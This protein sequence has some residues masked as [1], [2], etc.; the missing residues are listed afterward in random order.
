MRYLNQ[1][2]TI[3]LPQYD[4]WP[5]VLPLI[6]FAYRVLPHSTTRFSPFF[7]QYGREPRLPIDSSYKIQPEDLDI[8]DGDTV[9]YAQSMIDIMKRT[10]KLV[11][12]RQ[13]LAS[14]R[15]AERLDENRVPAIEY[16]VN[17]PVW[18]HE[19]QS[20]LGYVSSTRPTRLQDEHSI[21]SKW[22]F[23]WSGPHRIS[24]R[25]SDKVYR[26]WHEFRK[27]F[28]HALSRDLKIY[29]P[30]EP[31]TVPDVI[32]C[33]KRRKTLHGS[34]RNES[35]DFPSSPKRKPRKIDSSSSSS[36]TPPADDK[37]LF[38][39]DDTHR[40]K[41][42]D[43]CLV[44]LR[45]DDF[46]PFGILRYISRG[47]GTSL[48]LQYLG[49][50]KLDYRIDIFVRHSFQNSWYQPS[51]RQI[52]YKHGKLHSLH[53]PVTNVFVGEEI[54]T[55]DVIAFPF[56]LRSNFTLPLQIQKL[57]LSSHAKAFPSIS[58]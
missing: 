50:Y 37:P 25:T 35:D 21:P 28:I 56:D 8:E 47:E 31:L 39:P 14:L 11:R 22:R 6:L 36:T 4:Q 19:P 18:Y 55:T 44:R 27:K 58:T 32:T 53:L 3:I 57:I 23:S 26:I 40:L 7:L 52:Y 41:E 5:R 12:Y 15:N 33:R 54:L 30:F 24:S 45:G 10:F 16:K 38:G 20:V 48:I 43:L 42:G 9:A 13:N 34:E 49:N 29:H 46:Q 51:T 17:D 1:S 2:F